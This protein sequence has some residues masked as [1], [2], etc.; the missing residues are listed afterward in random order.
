MGDVNSAGTS[1]APE[2]RPI[3]NMQ[4][5]RVALG[6]RRRELMPLYEK[7]MND[8]DTLQLAGYP[9]EARTTDELTAWFERTTAENRLVQFDVYDIETWRP[10][11]F[12]MLKDIDT[13]HR[14][15]EFGIS[16]SE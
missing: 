11:G 14:T 3:I 13:Y 16:I 6:P 5:E 15:P 1:P 8:F 9:M 7:W 10:I 2:A 12:T 4:G